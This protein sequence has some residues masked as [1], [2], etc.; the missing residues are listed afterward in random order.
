MNLSE[1]LIAELTQ[2]AISTRKM[3][4]RVPLESFAWKP[5]EKSTSLVSLASHIADLPGFVV[6]A[7][8]QDELDFSAADFKPFVP[9]KPSDL[10]ERFDQNISQAIE[11]LK[12]QSNEDMLKSWR[13]RDGEQI[14][15]E[16]PRVG[17][18]RVMA[19]SHLVH[20]R[21]QLSVYL[22]LL[23]VPVPS[24]YGPSADEQ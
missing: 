15:F 20:H 19:L 6:P 14:F 4:E 24:I 17:V 10:V 7:L 8:T 21:G 11:L 23:N 22:R 2:E 1:P 12:S 18:V 9:E 16:M 3:L 5:H 13:L